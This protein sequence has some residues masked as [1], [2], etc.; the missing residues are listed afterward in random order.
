MN[1]TIEVADWI[2][3]D[4]AA[5]VSGGLAAFN[6]EALGPSRQRDLAVSVF[7]DDELV[8]GLA[9][10]TAWDWLFVK[11]LWIREDVRGQGLAARAV[12]TAERDAVKRGCRAAWLDTLNPDAKRLYERCGFVVFGELPD[13]FAGSTRF[14][15]QKRFELVSA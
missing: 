11:W 9:G 10:F 6:A 14:F 15:M 12:E 3:E 4:F 5:D 8:G 2:D 7:A 13:F 1:V